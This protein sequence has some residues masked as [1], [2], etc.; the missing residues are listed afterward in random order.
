MYDPKNAFSSKPTGVNMNEFPKR[1]LI[2][3][4]WIVIAIALFLLAMFIVCP[5]LPAF[6]QEGIVVPEPETYKPGDERAV[7]ASFGDIRKAQWYFESYNKLFIYSVKQEMQL[8]EWKSLY[9][10]VVLN[11]SQYSEDNKRLQSTILK[12]IN[13]KETDSE[14][15]K[16]KRKSDEKTINILA[17]FLAGTGVIAIG[18]IV[19][20]IVS[21]IE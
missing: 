16:T 18:S 3:G 17:G 20:A 4:L 12:I 2:V 15:E 8:M 11:S 9:N 21:N 6:E 13:Q 7:N 19:Y 5:T 14:N 10:T 1:R